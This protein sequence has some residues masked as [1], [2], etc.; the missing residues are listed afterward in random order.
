[1]ISKIDLDKVIDILLYLTE[2]I[3][4]L[5]VTKALK[6]FYY[7]DFIS[8]SERG[9]PITNDI[10]FKLPYGPIP[11][12][13]KNEIDN[14]SVGENSQLKDYF[15]IEKKGT[16]KLI[17]KNKGIKRKLKFSEYEKTLIGYVVTKIGKK[18]TSQIVEKTHKEKPYL[19]TEDNS[20]IDYSL[21]STLNG[22]KILA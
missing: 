9:A 14:L 3:E 12:F 7:L 8:L 2:N 10:Y 20:I 21:S 15:N 5:Y 6:I 16:S 18:G 13:I 4:S 11:S 19:L 17:K 1:M 22:R